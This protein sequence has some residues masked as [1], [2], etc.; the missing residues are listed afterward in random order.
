MGWSAR[1]EPTGIERWLARRTLDVLQAVGLQERANHLPRELSGG[2]MQRVAIARALIADPQI[3]VADEP[4]GSLDTKTGQGIIDLFKWLAHEQGIAILLT[5]HNPAF[6]SEADRIITLSDGRI[7][8]PS[9][10]PA[11]LTPLEV[12]V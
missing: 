8:T 11:R 2:Q 6:G 1:E 3:L 7:A 12:G 4:T 10:G 9:N 5:T